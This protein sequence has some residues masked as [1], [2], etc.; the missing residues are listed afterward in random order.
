MGGTGRSVG[1]HYPTMPLEEIAPCQSRRSPD[2]ALLFLWATAPKLYECMKVID[3]W[4]PH[5]MVWVKDKIGMG[6]YARNQHELLLVCRRGELP[7]R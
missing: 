1:N 4:S 3:A 7:P 5:S 2:D 6:Y